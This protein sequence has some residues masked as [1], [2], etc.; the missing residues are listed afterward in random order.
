MSTE[1]ERAWEYDHSGKPF[2]LG[3]D[4]HRQTVF[5]SGCKEVGRAASENLMVFYF[6]TA[7]LVENT[8][9]ALRLLHTF[10]VPQYNLNEK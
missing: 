10:L 5:Q 9:W 3:F 6:S 4:R 2:D 1:D 7:V 8:E